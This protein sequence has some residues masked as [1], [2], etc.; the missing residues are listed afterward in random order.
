MKLI[1]IDCE[2]TG[3]DKDRHGLWQIAGSVVISN[4]AKET[5]D[6]KAR[7]F[8]YDEV[9]DEALK[10]NGCTREL[11]DSYTDPQIVYMQLTEIIGR[12]VSK[13]DRTDKF[14]FIGWNADFDSDFVRKFFEKCGDKYFGSWFFWPVIDVTKLAG[15]YLME[16]RWRMPDFKLATVAMHL[17]VYE[18]TKLHDAS[19][20][21]ALTETIFN[22]LADRML[23]Q[24]IAK[25]RQ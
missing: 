16:D 20:D 11:L 19:N 5:F 4:R 10:V 8:P 21:I 3:T 14:H 23:P 25:T 15:L 2:T 13:Y 17:G 18:D 7:P 22:Y 1:F 24:Q 12:Y 6:L 9:D